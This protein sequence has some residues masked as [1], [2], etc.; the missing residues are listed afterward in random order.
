MEE[1]QSEE[2]WVP[3]TVKDAERVLE[4]ILAAESEIEALRN[5]ISAITSHVNAMIADKQRVID[6]LR[7]LYEPALE[8]IARR[9]LEGKKAKHVKTPFGRFG[10]R[11]HPGH[12]EYLIRESDVLDWCKR[13]YPDKVHR[14]EWVNKTEVA[15]LPGAEHLL[16]LTEP[17]TEFYINTAK[18]KEETSE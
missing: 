2:Q 1:T 7:Y 8:A 17:T 18:A 13:H 14:K 6:S 15:D 16:K 11:T 4:K 3:T 5:R 10:Y 12:L 9:E